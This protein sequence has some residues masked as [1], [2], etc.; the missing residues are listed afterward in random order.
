MKMTREQA[1]KIAIYEI[2][3]LIVKNGEDD[4]FCASPV[5]GHKQTWTNAEA[6]TA[7]TNDTC[8]EDS[9]MNLVDMILE[10]EE[11]LNKYANTSYLDKEKY[12]ELLNT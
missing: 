6:L 2:Q 9:N 3:E 1:Q 11:Y 5:H 12:K 7:A 10:H 4:I 8:L